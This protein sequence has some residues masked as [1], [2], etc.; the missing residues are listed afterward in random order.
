MSIA[1]VVGRA[2][3]AIAVISA[4]ARI[5]VLPVET[6]YPGGS[7]VLSLKFRNALEDLADPATATVTI[8]APTGTTLATFSLGQLTKLSTGVYQA[9]ATAASALGVYL[10]KVVSTGAVADVAFAKF[11]VIPNP[12]QL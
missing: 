9:P 7:P 3:A 11:R 10:V 12:E 4:R 5:E 8:T 6:F 2:R 1:L